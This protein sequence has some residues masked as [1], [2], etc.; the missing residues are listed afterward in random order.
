LVGIGLAAAVAT[1]GADLWARRSEHAAAAARRVSRIT[2]PITVA[3]VGIAATTAWAAATSTAAMWKRG[4]RHDLG[5][6][7]GATTLAI[8]GWDFIYY[9]NHR[10]MH[11]TRMMWAYHVVHHSSERY[12]LS[13]ALRQPVA[14]S[15]GLFA[16]YSALC[17]AGVR[18]ASV[19]MARGANLLYQYWFHTDAIGRMGPAEQVLN[20]PSHHRVHHASNRR[21]I[22][23]NHGS[24]LIVWDRLFGTFEREDVDEA[25]VYGLTKNIHTYNPWRIATTEYGDI[26]RDVSSATNWRDRL[27]FV[28]RGPGWSYRRHALDAATV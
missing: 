9:W 8:T 16:P 26:L 14:E 13:T 21:Y 11:T 25:V 24:I 27:S 1:T 20:T 17:L 5:A 15:L 18:P 3:A 28:L 7:L 6:G 23:R 12:N 4:K 22:D 10:W 2:G 19:E